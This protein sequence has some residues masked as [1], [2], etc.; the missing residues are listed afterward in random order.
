MHL[1]Q[2]AVV[3]AIP[4]FAGF[5]LAQQPRTESKTT[6]TTTTTSSFNGTL[7][8][9]SCRSTQTE[10]K[11]TK[12]DET[13]AQTKTT[14]SETVDCPVGPT[15]TSF[16]LLTSDGRF[17]RFDQA[18]NSKIAE[19]MKNEKKWN[20]EISEHAPVAVRVVGKPNGDV[21]VLES[22]E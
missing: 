20:R 16:G 11:E 3:T 8:D 1:K 15:T 9:A 22:I 19:M 17:V 14:R 12:S 13:G 21:I 2:F 6:T 7:M 5:L 4:L 10:T 18:S